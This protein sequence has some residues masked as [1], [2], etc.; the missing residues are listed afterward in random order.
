MQPDGSFT[1]EQVEVVQHVLG[2][3]GID[4]IDYV[5]MDFGALIPSLVAGH[6]GA[7]GL[8]GDFRGAGGDHRPPGRRP[9]RWR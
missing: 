4:S 2:E 6:R 3:M 5:A 9:T 8:R 1:G 7:C